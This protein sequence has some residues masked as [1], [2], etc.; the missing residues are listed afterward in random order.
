MNQVVSTAAGP[1]APDTRTV[2]RVEGIVQGVGFRPF[3]YS[4]AQR[5]GLAGHVA[6]D[7]RGV[8]VEVEGERSAIAGFVARLQS[9]APALAVIERVSAREIAPRGE[10]E[11]R[12][13]AS[14]HDGLRET[15][16]APDTATCADCLREIFD[17]SDRR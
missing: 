3:I 12:I 4:L 8:I 1:A 9:D 17:P 7:Q 16:I 11:F 6:N 15:L 14:R 2:V 13:I 5:F 10:R